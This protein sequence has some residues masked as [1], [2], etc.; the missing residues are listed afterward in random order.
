[1]TDTDRSHAAAL[2]AVDPLAA[3]RE[4]FVVASEQQVYLDGNSL[5]R[6]P[7]ATAARLAAVVHEDWGR[8][9]VGSWHDWVDLAY[10]VGDAIG[11]ALLGA[12]PGQ[13]VVADSTSVNLYKLAAAAL[14]ARP[15]RRVIVTDSRNFPSDRYVLEG[16][17]A[18]R[19]LELRLLATPTAEPVS[20]A[21]VAAALSEDVALV[22]LSLVDYCSGALADLQSVT[23]AAHA[24]GAL[25]LWDL[26]HAAGAVP[27]SLD[28]SKVDLA[29]GCTYKYLNAGPGAPAFLYVRDDLQE[30]LR[31]PIWGWFGQREQFRMGATYDPAPGITRYL[32]GSPPVLAMTAVEAGVE[33][34]A[35]VG[36]TALREKSVA[37]TDYVIA[38][39]DAWLEPLG[40][41]V[42]TPRAVARRGAHVALRHADAWQITQMLITRYDVI[43]DFREPDII[44]IGV[45]P[46]YT[47]FVD[48]WDALDRLRRGVA[49]GEHLTFAAERARVT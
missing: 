12:A 47:R 11:T 30:Q 6:L 28:D 45:P 14:D 26:C 9:L 27:I 18:A 5:G 15:D 8:G 42:G 17:A 38:L 2:D 13:T 33:V 22:S 43:P 48:G 21:D 46:A 23:A 29:V 31:Q 24:A 10:R 16:L 39:A 19:R 32:A 1:M 20:A 41:A 44:R 36:M 4:E 49:A 34:L 35:R 25:I 7:R 37:L 40:V 3:L